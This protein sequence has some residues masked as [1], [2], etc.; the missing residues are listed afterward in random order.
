[1]LS[2]NPGQRSRNNM[3]GVGG[4]SRVG[5][6]RALPGF[7]HL[8]HDTAPAPAELLVPGTFCSCQCSSTNTFLRNTQH[9]N[10]AVNEWHRLSISLAAGGADGSMATVLRG[11]PALGNPWKSPDFFNVFSLSST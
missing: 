4:F 10:L 6:G 5:V 11:L 8:S 7:G 1:M 2:R 9:H 3:E